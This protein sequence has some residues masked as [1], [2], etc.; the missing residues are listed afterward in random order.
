MT[1][2]ITKSLNNSA[3]LYKYIRRVQR[4]ISSSISICSYFYAL[5]VFLCLNILLQLLNFLGSWHSLGALFHNLT[6]TCIY[7]DMISMSWLFLLVLI[8]VT[9][10]C[11]SSYKTTFPLSL[12]CC[13]CC[14]PS[15][16]LHLHCPQQCFVNWNSS[17]FCVS[18]TISFLMDMSDSMGLS[19]HE[20]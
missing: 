1:D 9:K 7:I 16:K 17:E 6:S 8:D 2:F 5:P 18:C 4:L 13:C 15:G 3:D 11:P 10:L 19:D 14:C 20:R 12:F